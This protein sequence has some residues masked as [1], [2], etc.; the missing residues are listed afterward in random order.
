MSKYIQV[1]EL[2]KD[3]KYFELVDPSLNEVFDHEEVQKCIHI[4]LL[5]VEHYANDRPTMSDIILMLT[6]KSPIVSLPQKPA[7]YVQRYMY[8]E[9]LSSLELCTSSIVGI[10]SSTVE[11]TTS[12]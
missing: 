8:D 11:M 5:C 6:S 4:G 7:F 2:W 12:T 10:T 3:D 9:N 1:W